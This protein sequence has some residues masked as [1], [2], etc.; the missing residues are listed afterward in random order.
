MRVTRICETEQSKPRNNRIW[1]VKM[2]SSIEAATVKIISQSKVVLLKKLG[3]FH[4]K[5]LKFWKLDRNTLISKLPL[6]CPNACKSR[7]RP[8]IL[9]GK[10]GSVRS[11][12]YQFSVT[13]L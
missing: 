12:Y 10:Q 4:I 8:A 7:N 1:L 6:V 9:H 2:K 3:N 13:F 11:S 5:T